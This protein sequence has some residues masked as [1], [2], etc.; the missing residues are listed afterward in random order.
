MAISS[1]CTRLRSDQSAVALFC[2][3]SLTIGYLG[4]RLLRLNDRQAIAT[5]MEVGVHN[6]TV[7][8]TIAL[9]VLDSIDVAIPIAV[10]SIVMYPLA[11][12]FGWAVTRTS[13]GDDQGMPSA[14][15]DQAGAAAPRH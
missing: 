4:A 13:S 9:S 2:A 11:A 7:A 1:R 6:T 10:Y 14:T 15:A 8:L 5:S 3:L 12:V